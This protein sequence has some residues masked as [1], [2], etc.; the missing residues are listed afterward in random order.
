MNAIKPPRATL[1]QLRTFEAI[2]RL[3][4]ITRAA[5][6][7]HLAQPTVSSQLRELTDA[8]GVPLLVPAGR[9]VQLTDA[10][11]ALQHTA[12]TMFSQWSEFEETVADLQ[13]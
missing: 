4:G 11:R 5:Q 6:A 1:T 3:G 9:G 7:L 12:L 8:V 2:A 10:G 13:G